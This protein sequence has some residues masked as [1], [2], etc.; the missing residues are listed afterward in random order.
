[1][2]FIIGFKKN[3]YFKRKSQLIQ[4]K[5]LL[6]YFLNFY[7]HKHCTVMVSAG[8]LFSARL[9]WAP[10]DYENWGGAFD[11]PCPTHRAPMP[12]CNIQN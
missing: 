3:N 11:L 6:H 4:I 12:A 7:L 1:M 5:T 10:G 2:H 8:R 9:A